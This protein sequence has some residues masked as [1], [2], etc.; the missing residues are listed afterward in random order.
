MIRPKETRG[1]AERSK[2]KVVEGLDG[3]GSWTFGLQSGGDE[4]D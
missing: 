2:V 1:E 4:V 3:E